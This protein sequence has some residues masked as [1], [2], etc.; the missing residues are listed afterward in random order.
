MNHDRLWLPHFLHFQL[1]PSSTCTSAP[2]Y[3]ET[4]PGALNYDL[5]LKYFG[6]QWK[7][8]AVQELKPTSRKPSLPTLLHSGP[9][10]LSSLVLLITNHIGKLGDRGTFT[11]VQQLL[12]YS[13]M[14]RVPCGVKEREDSHIEE[15]V[16]TCEGLQCCHC[17]VLGDPSGSSGKHSKVNPAYQYFFK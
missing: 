12:G 2:S 11:S 17:L 1:P 5:C 14:Y 6:P 4:L 7:I 13:K 16:V 10:E 9:S 8:G 3:L 15:Y